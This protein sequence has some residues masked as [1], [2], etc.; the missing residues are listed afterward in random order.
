MTCNCC[1]REFEYIAVHASFLGPYSFGYCEEC[2]AHCA[3]DYRIVDGIVK[4]Q[5]C[6]RATRAD[7]VLEECSVYVNGEYMNLKTYLEQNRER[8]FYEFGIDR[9]Q[10]T[11]T[12]RFFEALSNQAINKVLIN[13]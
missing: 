13:H 3:E 11:F 1:D 10:P 8:Y 12:S 2:D 5:Q 4:R 6:I 7:W 9:H